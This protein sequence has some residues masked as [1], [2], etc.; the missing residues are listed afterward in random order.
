M[1]AFT[2]DDDDKAY[3][4]AQRALAERPTFGPSYGTLA[5]IDALHGRTSAAQ[6]NMAEHL[7]L[8]PYS[9]VTRYIANNPGGA[10]RYLAGRNRMVEGLRM[11]GLPE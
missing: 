8:M 7:R 3:A 2:L 9:T 11:A 4:L 6:K 10:P 5:A 1:L